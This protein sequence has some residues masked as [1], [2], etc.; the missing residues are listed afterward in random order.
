ML[1]RSILLA[2]AIALAAPAAHAAPVVGQA[3][4]GADPCVAGVLKMLHGLGQPPSA[5]V[6]C[7]VV[8]QRHQVDARSLQRSGELGVGPEAE[9]LVRVL[10]AAPRNR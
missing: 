6:H 2:A 5:E 3:A 9:A 4:R 7:V 8:G 10:A 1:S